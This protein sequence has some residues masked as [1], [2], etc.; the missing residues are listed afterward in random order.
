MFLGPLSLNPLLFLLFKDMWRS[1]ENQIAKKWFKK[2][3]KICVY[4]F[5]IAEFNFI[6]ISPLKYS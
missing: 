4:V 3:E 6:V 2:F 5:G 1:F